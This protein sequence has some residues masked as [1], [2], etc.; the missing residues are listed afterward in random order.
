MKK[1]KYRVTLT[2]DLIIEAFSEP[3][4]RLFAY[5]GYGDLI[6]GSQ[7]AVAVEQEE[8]NYVSIDHQNVRETAPETET[9]LHKDVPTMSI[10]KLNE[11]YNCEDKHEQVR[12]IKAYGIKAFHLAYRDWLLLVKFVG[13]RE[14]DRV[15]ANTIESFHKLR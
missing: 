3:Q 4:A 1:I 9:R 12:L 15:Y 2:K 6:E 11:I 13:S 8:L 5:K 10:D 7:S 14:A